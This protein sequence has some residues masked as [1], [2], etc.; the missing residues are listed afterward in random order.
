METLTVDG[1][2]VRVHRQGTGRPLVYLHSASAEVGPIPFFA[3]LE[4]L[5]FSVIAA[6]LPGFGTAEPVPEWRGIH[7]AVFHVRRA[8]DELEIGRA[9][10]VG[11]SFGGWL[12][13][14]VAVW[15]PDRFDA[16]VLLDSLGL[17]VEGAPIGDVFGGPGSDPVALM[18]QANPHGFDLLGVLA[19]CLDR[20]EDPHA[21]TLHLLRGLQGLARLGWDP[22]MHDPRL[23]DR[24]STLTVPTLVIWG[25]DDGVVPVAHGAAYADAIPG[26]TLKVVPKSGHAPA[27]EHPAEVAEMIGSFVGS[28]A[29]T[30]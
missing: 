12:A 11:S 14:E 1:K 9:T 21:L 13:A 2:R 30:A 26:A 22:Y 27:F 16:L 29:V 5:G 19:A 4:R 20:P 17:V 8:L 10:L 3:E 6:E 15:F 25:E 28:A 7:D 24:L 23:R 18:A